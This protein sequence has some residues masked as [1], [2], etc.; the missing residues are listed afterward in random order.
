MD[1]QKAKQISDQN[2]Y[3]IKKYL[4]CI[5]SA[6]KVGL[7]A[8]EIDVSQETFCRLQSIQY[9]LML[10]GFRCIS[11]SKMLYISWMGDD[12]ELQESMLRN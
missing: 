8:T 5:E 12:L 10:L 2:N 9:K 7:Y 1:K 6:A 4:D 3:S 11:R